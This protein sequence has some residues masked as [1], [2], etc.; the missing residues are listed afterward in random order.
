MLFAAKWSEALILWYSTYVTKVVIVISIDYLLMKKYANVV[1]RW[2]KSLQA[3]KK[4]QNK[5]ISCQMYSNAYTL[6]V[7]YSVL[8]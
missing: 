7:T 4:P 6:H 3:I 8:E 1:V 2:P 5:P